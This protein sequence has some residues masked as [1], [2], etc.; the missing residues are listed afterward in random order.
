MKKF[1]PVYVRVPVIFAIFF[2]GINLIIEPVDGRPAFLAYPSVL[3]LIVLFAFVQIAVEVVNS[4]TNKVLDR[5]MTPEELAERHRKENIPFSETIV[6]KGEKI[7]VINPLLTWTTEDLE[8]F[9][10]TLTSVLFL[11]KKK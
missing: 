4:A 9:N 10:R 7:L 11:P 1:F 8:T 3:I 6:K 5:L 2:I